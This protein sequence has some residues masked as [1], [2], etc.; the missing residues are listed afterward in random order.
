MGCRRARKPTADAHNV[1]DAPARIRPER[2]LFYSKRVRAQNTHLLPRDDHPHNRPQPRLGA[3]LLARTPFS[4]L[5]SHR[6]YPRSY[7]HLEV[8]RVHRP[9]HVHTLSRSPHVRLYALARSSGSLILLPAFELA[10][11][12]VRIRTPLPALL[13]YPPV[14]LIPCRRRRLQSYLLWPT[15]EPPFVPWPY[16]VAL[17]YRARVF[18]LR[19][20]AR[21][22]SVFQY[23]LCNCILLKSRP[24]RPF[25][26]I[27]SIPCAHAP[28]CSWYPSNIAHLAL[29][30]YV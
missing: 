23:P 3:P 21:S 5:F 18:R 1:E 17:G 25:L 22:Y 15:S 9:S 20:R 24:S 16:E 2:A 14:A 7:T 11:L 10:P 13:A 28:R 6:A 8:E 27:L 4:F 12:F 26:E 29:E 19:G 30:N